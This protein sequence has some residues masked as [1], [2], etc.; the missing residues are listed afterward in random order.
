MSRILPSSYRLLAVLTVVPLTAAFALSQDD[1]SPQ[2]SGPAPAASAPAAQNAENPPLSGLDRPTSE[3][4]FGGRSYLIP[5]LQLSEA[6]D[7]N[8]A[9]SGGRTT[10]ASRGLGALDLQKIWKTYQVGIDYL[11]GGEYYT[12]SRPAGQNRAYQLHSLGSDQRLLWRTGQLSI[13]DTFSYLPEGSFG[14]GS[15]GG[16]GGFSS[17]L[18]N[19]GISGV[20]AG[21]GLG[22]GIA[23]GTPTGLFG[24]G[25]FGTFSIQPRI[26]NLSIIDI[27]QG[28]SPRSTATIGGGYN[29]TDYLNKSQSPFPIINS[30][31]TT[32]QVG[33]DYLISRKSQIGLVG[34]F[35]DFHFPRAG[36]GNIQ[37]YVVNALYGHR[38]S[39]RLNLVIGGGPQVVLIGSSLV[40]VAGTFYQI[41]AK[42]VVDGSGS[43]TLGYT[44]TSR[45][46]LSLLYH[47]YVT[48]GSGFLAGA[49]TDAIRGTAAHRFGRKWSG[50]ADGGYSRHIALQSIIPNVGINSHSYH[51]WYAGGTL[52]R[53]LGRSFSAFGTYQYDRFGAGS[54]SNSAGSLSVCGQSRNR[55]TGV[56][57]L[58][59][60]PHPIRLD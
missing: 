6:I 40:N 56:V 23:G 32:A 3:P 60:H 30:Q 21:S 35:Q 17:A 50:D 1:T 11:A 16:F 52:H 28:L 27:V 57:G 37:A 18:G 47:H 33:Y 53:Q 58:V 49:R 22:G 9:L 31:Q 38:I 41:P 19:S 8:S 54:C 44:V 59:W 10:E 20:G 5:G 45:T 4:A 14:L 24:G 13:R 39:G 7:S 55:H 2:T 12:G 34:A 25:Q 46:H 48:A 51:Y 15:F 26:D 42:T 36:V 43:V 29:F